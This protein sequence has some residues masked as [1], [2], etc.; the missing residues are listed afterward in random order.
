MAN[1][2]TQAE[3]LA[4]CLELGLI[5][6]ANAVAWADV[7]IGAND[8]PHIALCDVAM[9]SRAY[10]FDVASMLRQLPGEVDSASV[11]RRIVEHCSNILRSGCVSPRTIASAL[12]ELAV[13]KTLPPGKLAENALWFYDALDLATDGV[14]RE[15]P[16]QVVQQ[17]REVID[18]ALCEMNVDEQ[19][20]A[21]GS[22][23]GPVSKGKRSPPVP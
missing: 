1:Q 3:V 23:A 22:A 19:S 2:R 10:S 8:V 15:T 5:E 21:P 17:M 9:A 4:S 6:V 11:V 13:D 12:Y 18:D 20:R 16:E 14:I 7:Q